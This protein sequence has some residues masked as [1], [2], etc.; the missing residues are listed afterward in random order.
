[1]G[2]IQKVVQKL[3]NGSRTKSIVED[4]GKPEKSIKFSDEWSRTIHELGNIELHELEQISRTVQHQSCLKHVPGLIFCACGI[5]LRPDE[6]TI[7]RIKARF[8]AMIVPY[9]LARVNY[10]RGK[11]HGEAQ[12][13]RDHWKAMDPR[14]GARKNNHK[15]IVL[16]WQNVEKDRQSQT[17][18]GWTEEFCRYLE[19]LTTIDISYTA[20]W[21]QTPVR[22]APSRWCATMRIVKL[23]Q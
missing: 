1:M 22:E 8:E 20:P 2:Q 9:Y 5:C 18:H 14:R 17:R 16:R 23:N 7:Q 19:H 21:H 6:A 4:L 15:S 11:R 12:W 3:R 10:S 13:Q